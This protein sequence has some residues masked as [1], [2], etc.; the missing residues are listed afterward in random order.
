MARW[1]PP[2]PGAHTDMKARDNDRPIVQ[3][4]C[5]IF[6]NAWLC[7]GSGS[8]GACCHAITLSAI[9]LEKTAAAAWRLSELFELQNTLSM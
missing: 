5:A 3:F 6:F 8:Y 4:L 9:I 1:I 2:P 7:G